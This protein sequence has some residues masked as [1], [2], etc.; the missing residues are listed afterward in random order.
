LKQLKRFGTFDFGPRRN[1]ILPGV[2]L[3]DQYDARKL[4]GKPGWTI[5]DVRENDTDGDPPSVL[6]IPLIRPDSGWNAGLKA[7]T[8]IADALDAAIAK[9]TPVL[10]HCWAGMER[11]PLALAVWLTMRCGFTLDDA[12]Y[13]LQSRR[14]IFDRR[15]WLTK[16]ARRTL[17]RAPGRVA[18]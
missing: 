13:L 14:N 10:I 12:Y 17:N 2:W 11:S 1:E 3:G 15:A 6:R 9:G 4:W 8:E 5:I 16:N 7:L 18:A